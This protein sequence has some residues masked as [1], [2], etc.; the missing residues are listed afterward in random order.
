LASAG[1]AAT[2][3]GTAAELT[4][5]YAPAS[6]AAVQLTYAVRA[7]VRMEGETVQPDLLSAERSAFLDA[8][9]A[10]ASAVQGLA[11]LVFDQPRSQDEARALL[12]G[13]RLVAETQTAALAALDRFLLR[14]AD[15]GVD[16]ETMA[17][18]PNGRV[19]LA[20]SLG[21]AL[22]DAERAELLLRRM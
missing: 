5:A 21:I 14:C 16:P 9:T 7:T 2:E 3:A 12:Q 18:L 15:L 6:L 20:E 13:L 10:V 22:A 4:P 1:T 11:E 19:D 8:S 17:D